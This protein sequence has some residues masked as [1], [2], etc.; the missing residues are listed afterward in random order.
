LPVAD[1]ILRTEHGVGYGPIWLN[2]P[3]LEALDAELARLAAF[4]DDLERRRQRFIVNRKG[5]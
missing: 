2:E 5:T 1:V 3:T 4:R